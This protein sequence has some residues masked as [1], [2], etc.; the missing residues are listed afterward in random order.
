MIYA[1]K[2]LKI[3]LNFNKKSEHLEIIILEHLKIII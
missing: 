2:L 3:M 1:F